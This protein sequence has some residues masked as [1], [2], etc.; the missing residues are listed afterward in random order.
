[1]QPESRPLRQ[2]RARS[3]GRGSWA[4]WLARCWFR[5]PDG[6]M[7]QRRW[8]DALVAAV[9]LGVVV[10]CGVL[11]ANRLVLGTDVAVF[12]RINHWPG[13]LYPP[14]DSPV[15]GSDR[16]SSPGGSRGRAVEEAALG[17]CPGGRDTAEGIAGDRDPDVRAASPAPVTSRHPAAAATLTHRTSS[18]ACDWDTKPELS[19]QEDVPVSIT[20]PQD[21][22]P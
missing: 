5:A 15:V 3:A 2:A 18:S 21:N 9:G 17:R 4:R 6:R 1:M 13:W 11:V 10:V 16:G 7:Y 19:H 12:R 20:S 22:R 8:A 14:V